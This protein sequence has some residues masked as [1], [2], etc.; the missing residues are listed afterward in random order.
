MT[1]FLKHSSLWDMTKVDEA[2]KDALTSSMRKN[3]TIVLS[4]IYAFFL[5]PLGFLVAVNAFDKYIQGWRGALH[6]IM[7]ILL[8]GLSFWVQSDL[9]KKKAQYMLCGLVVFA[10]ICLFF[11]IKT[12]E[13]FSKEFVYDVDNKNN[14]C[15]SPDAKIGTFLGLGCV[16]TIYFVCFTQAIGLLFLKSG[17]N[18]LAVIGFPILIFV[19]LL[20]EF[21]MI[22]L[23]LTISKENRNKESNN[24]QN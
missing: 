24:S 14:T 12:L 4:L 6:I 7:C 11:T 13:I 18:R 10:H 5:V 16:A 2:I 9:L 19:F 3:I 17:L 15:K 8:V 20:I 1:A 23:S 22:W 21:A